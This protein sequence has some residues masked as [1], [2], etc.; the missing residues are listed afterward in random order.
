MYMPMMDGLE[1]T[2]KLRNNS[3]EQLRKLPVIILTGNISPE[4]GTNMEKAGVSDYLI[5][6]FQR[7]ELI[8][9]VRKHL[10]DHLVK[11]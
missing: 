4:A 9:L 10:S 8:E 11:S 3:D 6:P 5:K 1:L 2:H 7:R